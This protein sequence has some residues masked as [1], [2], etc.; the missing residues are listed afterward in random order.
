MKDIIVMF[1]G[2][3]IIFECADENLAGWI[4]NLNKVMDNPNNDTVCLGEQYWFRANR[5]VGFYFREHYVGPAEKMANLLEKQAGEGE[6][7]RGDE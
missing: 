5:L 1:D 3:H 7:W 4:S 2:N 6:E